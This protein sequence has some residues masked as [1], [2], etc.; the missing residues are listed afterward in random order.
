MLDR[1]KNYGPLAA[2]YVTVLGWVNLLSLNLGGAIWLWLAPALRR[3]SNRC[4]QATVVL[5]AF[6]AA[7]FCF[8]PVLLLVH[9]PRPKLRVFGTELHVGG[10]VLMVAAVASAVVFL[11]PML[12]LLA[13]GTRAAFQ[14]RAERGLCVR[15]GY[16]LRA[17]VI[18]CPECGTPIPGPAGPGSSV[19][20]AT[21]SARGI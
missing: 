17:S 15:C 2:T 16:D 3:R 13:P 9:G 14:R 1:F 19:A 11:V 10:A 7:M 12:W 8:V 4:R 5:L 6:H 20:V 18:R 21:P